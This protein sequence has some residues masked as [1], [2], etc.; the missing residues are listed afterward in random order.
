MEPDLRT[1]EREAPTRWWGPHRANA[2]GSWVGSTERGY[3]YPAS[4]D[5]TFAS[6]SF[7]ASHIDGYSPYQRLLPLLSMRTKL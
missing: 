7:G 1:K 2:F 3:H 4:A 5:V 6:S